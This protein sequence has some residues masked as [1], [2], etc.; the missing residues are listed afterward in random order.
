MFLPNTP[1]PICLKPF[2]L[3]E[4][5]CKAIDMKIIFH[6]CANELK[7]TSKVCTLPCFESDSLGTQKWPILA[8]FLSLNAHE[9]YIMDRKGND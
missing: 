7:F 5:K 1:F 4:A 2:F 9:K 6:S 8:Y 3:S